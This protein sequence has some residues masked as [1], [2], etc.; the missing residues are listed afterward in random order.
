MLRSLL[1]GGCE[2]AAVLLRERPRPVPIPI[3]GVS[4]VIDMVKVDFDR[5]QEL[6]NNLREAGLDVDAVLDQFP[7]MHPVHLN[8]RYSREE[9]ELDCENEKASFSQIQDILQCFQV[10]AD[11]AAVVSAAKEQNVS[12]AT[13]PDVFTAT[14]PDVLAATAPDVL[15]ST[16]PDVLAATAPDVFAATAPDVFAATAPDVLDSY[17]TRCP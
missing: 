9:R 10:S 3:T 14:A 16:A 12:A 4:S 15:A 1:N 7:P 8:P 2:M 13:A 17:S 5:Y 6:V 11:K